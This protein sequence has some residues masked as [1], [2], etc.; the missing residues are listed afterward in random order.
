[1]NCKKAAVVELI[2]NW[3]KGGKTYCCDIHTPDW[4][5]QGKKKSPAVD[6]AGV[7]KSFYSLGKKIRLGKKAVK[8]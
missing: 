8:Q 3:G 6:F 1:M 7:K 2:H 4:V 5:K